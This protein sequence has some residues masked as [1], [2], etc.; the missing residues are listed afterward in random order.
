MKFFLGSALTLS[1]SALAS[2][3]RTLTVRGIPIALPFELR[4]LVRELGAG[5]T[6]DISGT[7]L[8]DNDGTAVGDTTI[9]CSSVNALTLFVPQIKH[10]APGENRVWM[11]RGNGYE[12]AIRR[13]LRLTPAA[14]FVKAGEEMYRNSLE[15]YPKDGKLY[16]INDIGIEEYL[17]GLVNRE[18][19]SD[20]P[21]EAVKAQI[22]AARSYALATAADRRHLGKFFDLYGTIQDQV[23]RG[24]TREDSRSFRIVR[25]TR[26]EVL[27]HRDDVLKSYY[28]AASGGFSELPQH[29]W[30]DEERDSLAYLARTSEADENVPGSRW[31]ITL[32]SQIGLQWPGIGKLVDLRVLSRTP[33]R[34][35]QALEIVGT[36]GN[37]TLNGAEF[38]KKLGVNWVKSTYFYVR[39]VDQGWIL[40]GRGFGHGVGLSQL[41]AKAMAAE[42]KTSAEI[43]NFYYPYSD[44]RN[45]R[46][47][48]PASEIQISAR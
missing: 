17:A 22:I 21:I 38:R 3:P 36:D 44:V 2:T 19:R 1:C 30:G 6:L 10:D 14:G 39:R 20:Y 18:I 42:N 32:S 23:Y 9:R 40:E 35:V 41:G 25:A 48:E 11:C 24:A 31:S 7:E 4:V 29:V 28:H 15:L 16:V 37:V 43:L 26:G 13:P 27:F 46:L 12:K 5:E 33:G 45:I 34:R 47:D 8:K